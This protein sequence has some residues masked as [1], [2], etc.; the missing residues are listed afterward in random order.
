MRNK[1]LTNDL[2]RVKSTGCSL[3][4]L[5]KILFQISE[6]Y[7][8]LEINKTELEMYLKLVKNNNNQINNLSMENDEYL[9]E[10]KLIIERDGIV[11]KELNC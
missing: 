6:V 10:I 7:L 8:L 4:T 5:E 1:K 3:N 11:K 2:E 9:N